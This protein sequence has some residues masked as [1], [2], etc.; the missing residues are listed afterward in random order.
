MYFHS[1]RASH[2]I[3]LFIMFL[4]MLVSSETSILTKNKKTS[5]GQRATAK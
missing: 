5:E 1:I 2:S 3:L 4:T